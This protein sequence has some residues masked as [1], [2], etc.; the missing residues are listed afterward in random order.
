[1]KVEALIKSA[2]QCLYLSKESGRDC[3]RGV[4]IP[5]ARALPA[6]VFEI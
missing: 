5:N 6:G 1:L 3:T 4:E 2:D